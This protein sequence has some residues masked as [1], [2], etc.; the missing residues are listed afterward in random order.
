MAENNQIDNSIYEQLGEKW[1][2]ADDDPVALLRA[3]NKVKVQWITQRLSQ[4]QKIL[5][6][7]CG[8]GFLTNALAEKGFS[9]TGVDIS[10]DSLRVARLYDK[11]QTV[12]Y[13]S[14]DAYALPF[15][16]A[17]FDIVTSMDFLEH[18]D[19]PERAIR[20]CARVL[21]P[22]GQF[23]FHTFNRN[24]LAWLVVIKIVEWLI[25][26][27]PKNMHVLRLFIKPSECRRYCEKNQ[28]MVA[29]LTGIKP[30]LRTIPWLRLFSGKVPATLRFE[31]TPSTLLSY[32]GR[33]TKKS[34]VSKD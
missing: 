23:F 19:D 26:N 1:Y 29:E 8:A 17:S 4:G 3:E 25:P 30:V 28:M 15:P 33:A 31:T 11:T 12:Q 13:V 24:F 2:T 18:V 14:A 32:L 10:S 6:V 34:A 21:K 5:D 7:G 9:V 22:G 16:D 20:E 27:T